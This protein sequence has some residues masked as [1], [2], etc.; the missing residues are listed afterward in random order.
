MRMETKIGTGKICKHKAR[1]NAHYGEEEH[2]ALNHI[3]L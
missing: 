3:Y 1:L 2:G